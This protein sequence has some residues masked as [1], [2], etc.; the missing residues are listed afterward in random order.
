LLGLL[1]N[2]TSAQ[3]N[4]LER[5]LSQ[6]D[7]AKLGA[8]IV[9]PTPEEILEFGS[10]YEEIRGKT[11]PRRAAAKKKITHENDSCKILIQTLMFAANDQGPLMCWTSR[12]Q[13]SRWGSHQ[14]RSPLV[15]NPWT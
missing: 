7:V 1:N 6:E 8:L 15:A 5:K 3:K 10:L 11:R 13:P 9:E 14:A 2:L 4:R 12:P